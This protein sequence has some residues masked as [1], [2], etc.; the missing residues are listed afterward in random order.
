M[1]ASA[2][3]N[4]QRDGESPA[5]LPLRWLI[6]VTSLPPGSE[7]E[8]AVVAQLRFSAQSIVAQSNWGR[9]IPL[10][11][12]TTFPSDPANGCTFVAELCFAPC[13]QTP[14][15]DATLRAATVEWLG[16]CKRHL[17]EQL[18]QLLAGAGVAT[19]RDE[20]AAHRQPLLPFAPP[21]PI[22]EMATIHFTAGQVA[23]H[24]AKLSPALDALGFPVDFRPASDLE[25]SAGAVARAM[26]A[27]F[28]NQQPRTDVRRFVAAAMFVLCGSELDRKRQKELPSRMH[29]VISREGDKLWEDLTQEIERPP[30][31]PE[32]LRTELRR[33]WGVWRQTR[34]STTRTTLESG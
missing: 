14:C 19:W 5:E 18:E 7:V 15:P 33:R 16:L 1:S 31:I 21:S 3:P 8:A 12:T 28:R 6:E 26:A 34:V 2:R 13:S 32:V 4:G 23:A 25:R 10:R 11:G 30:D 9:R 24:S 29:E 17:Q 27:V 22:A 20:G